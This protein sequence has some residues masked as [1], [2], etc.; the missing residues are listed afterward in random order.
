MRHKRTVCTASCSGQSQF[1]WQ[2]RGE[3]EGC[4][5]R[6][7]TTQP[8]LPVLLP[9]NPYNVAALYIIPRA[10][11]GA[12]ALSHPTLCGTTRRVFYPTAHSTI[13]RSS[14]TQ[15]LYATFHE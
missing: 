5:T 7:S 11:R 3:G 8:A 13:R 4:N 14:A 9:T 2:R 1:Q 12:V 6:A 15:Y 10:V